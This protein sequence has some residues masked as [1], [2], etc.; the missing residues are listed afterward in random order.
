MKTAAQTYRQN[1]K[2][3]YRPDQIGGIVER[4]EKAAGKDFTEDEK[5]VLDFILFPSIAG[6]DYYGA[7]DRARESFERL[8]EKAKEARAETDRIFEDIRQRQGCTK[9]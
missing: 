2:L 5:R 3:E 6:A 4:C 1:K 8:I 7:H 9:G